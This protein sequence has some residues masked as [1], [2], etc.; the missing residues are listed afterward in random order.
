MVT[1]KNREGIDEVR[2]VDAAAA[3]AAAARCIV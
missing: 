2:G 3:A 1:E